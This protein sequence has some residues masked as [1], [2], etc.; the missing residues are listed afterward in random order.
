MSEEPAEYLDLPCRWKQDSFEMADT[1]NTT[2]G[3]A[4]TFTEGAPKDNGFNYCP[5]CGNVLLQILI[6]DKDQ[7]AS[8]AHA[9]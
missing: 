3:N 5:Y 1:F 9:G 6:D 2:C 4:F 8:H 7:T